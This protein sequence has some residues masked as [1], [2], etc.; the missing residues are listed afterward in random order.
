MERWNDGTKV[1]RQTGAVSACHENWQRRLARG[2][3]RECA[4]RCR[5]DCVVGWMKSR[6]SVILGGL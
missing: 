3:L 2:T 1:G 4:V 6:N 5:K